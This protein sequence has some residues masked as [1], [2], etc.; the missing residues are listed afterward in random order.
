M[1]CQVLSAIHIGGVVGHH[2]LYPEPQRAPHRPHQQKVL[3]L[4][5]IAQT[6]PND[7]AAHRSATYTPRG[8]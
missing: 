2:P 1:P 7:V 5:M 8:G 3:R 6:H 4:D